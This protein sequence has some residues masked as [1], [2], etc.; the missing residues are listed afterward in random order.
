V[1]ANTALSAIHSW[2]A[3][4]DLDLS[5]KLMSLVKSFS[6]RNLTMPDD[7]LPALS[8]IAT[9]F[10]KVSRDDYNASL[11]KSNLAEQLLWHQ[12]GENPRRGLPPAYRAPSWSWAAVDGRVSFSVSASI[13]SA[14]HT[15]KNLINRIFAAIRALRHRDCHRL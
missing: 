4:R 12:I 3:G 9:E 1:K 6:Q 5:Q 7:K 2:Q 13:S 11:W 15:K 8:G 10:C 14:V